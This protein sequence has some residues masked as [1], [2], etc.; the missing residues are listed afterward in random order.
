MELQIYYYE[1]LLSL[2]SDLFMKIYFHYNQTFYENSILREF[3]AIQYQLVKI[4]AIAVYRNMPK[5]WAASLKIN[6][7]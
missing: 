2:K 4:V 1:N 3:G 7:S 6:R 5:L